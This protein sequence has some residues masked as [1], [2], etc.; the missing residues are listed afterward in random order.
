MENKIKLKTKQNKKRKCHEK[1]D[2]DIAAKDLYIQY[3]MTAKG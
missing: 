2:I 3:L 1:Q